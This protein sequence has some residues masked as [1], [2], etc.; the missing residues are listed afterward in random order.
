MNAISEDITSKVMKGGSKKFY[1]NGRPFLDLI[2]YNLYKNRIYIFRG[3]KRIEGVIPM[4]GDP[5]WG[6][7]IFQNEKEL[8]TV[9]EAAKESYILFKESLQ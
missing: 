8:N 1:T 6:V 9:L 3:R 4:K 2:T 5:K 7:I